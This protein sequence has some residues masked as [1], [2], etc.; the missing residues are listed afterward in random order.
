MGQI[1]SPCLMCYLKLGKQ[2][3]MQRVA[4][5]EGNAFCLG[6]EHQRACEVVE[7]EDVAWVV[8]ANGDVVWVV[9]EN[10]VF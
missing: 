3:A 1:E 4:K 6:S 8:E 9:V 2:Q 10:E 7:S 5:V